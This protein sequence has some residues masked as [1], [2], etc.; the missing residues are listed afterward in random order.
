MAQLSSDDPMR[1]KD[2]SADDITALDRTYRTNLINQ[3]SGV[4]TAFLAG[5][6]NGSGQTNL[7]LFNTLLHVGANPP[8]LGLVFRPLTAP[9][10]TYDNIRETGVFTLNLVHQDLIEPAHVCS[11][12]FPREVSE[13]DAAE[14]TPE[15]RFDFPAPFVGESRL[16]LAMSWEEEHEIQSNQTIFMVARIRHIRLLEAALTA[17]GHLDTQVTQPAGVSGLD[18]YFGVEFIRQLEYARSNA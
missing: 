9:R 2:F 7:A 11:A 8:L 1:Y 12:K 5:T 6:V 16:Q 15:Y 13:F 10:H 3:I 17:D 18:T 4:R 14:L